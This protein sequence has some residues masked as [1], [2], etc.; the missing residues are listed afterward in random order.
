[1]DIN[2]FIRWYKKVDIFMYNKFPINNKEMSANKGETYKVTM[3]VLLRGAFH[4]QSWFVV[5][6]LRWL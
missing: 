2:H 3:M 1:M 5:Y 4:I 6:S